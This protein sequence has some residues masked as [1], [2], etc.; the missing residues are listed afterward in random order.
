MNQLSG[1]RIIQIL[2]SILRARLTPVVMTLVVGWIA[3]ANTWDPV[4]A[5]GHLDP[6]QITSAVMTGLTLVTGYLLTYIVRLL[7]KHVK[8]FQIL[9]QNSGVIAA[10]KNDGLFDAGVL[11]AAVAAINTDTIKVTRADV[12]VAKQ[13]A[14]VK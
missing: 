13:D 2:I 12:D 14:G 1:D 3:K 4:I 7:T 11:K 10:G 6:N 5:N 9:L 8:A